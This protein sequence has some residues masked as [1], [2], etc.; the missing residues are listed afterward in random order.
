MEQHKGDILTII[1]FCPAIPQ[2]HSP[3]IKELAWGK[4]TIVLSFFLSVLAQ[5]TW[6]WQTVN[7]KGFNILLVTTHLP[8]MTNEHRSSTTPTP[9]TC[10]VFFLHVEIWVV[11]VLAIYS[12][13]TPRV[14][15]CT[16]LQIL[17]MPV[18]AVTPGR[19]ENQSKNMHSEFF[20]F[21]VTLKKYLLHTSLW[22]KL[23]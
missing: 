19:S 23:K 15:T 21:S 20:H 4:K 14:A 7:F 9:S 1:Y 12:F 2:N 8:G 13:P 10:L 6:M 5:E 11:L 3:P 22:Q 18:E 16:L 17:S